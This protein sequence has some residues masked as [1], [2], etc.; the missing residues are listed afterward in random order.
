MSC[1]S[2]L[3][4]FYEWTSAIQ[5]CVSHQNVMPKFT[6]MMTTPPVMLLGAAMTV[7]AVLLIQLRF[8]PEQTADDVIDSPKRESKSTRKRRRISENQNDAE[9]W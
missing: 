7:T 6:E 9:D 3:P 8:Y 2:V 5:E 4:L 1:S